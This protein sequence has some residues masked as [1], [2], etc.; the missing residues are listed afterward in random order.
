MTEAEA[1]THLAQ[2]L[3]SFTTGSILHLLADLHRDA[4][5]EARQNDDAIAFEQ[6]RLVEH[7]LVVVGMG[8]DAARP[9]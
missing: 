4:A 6:A 9:T 8:I 1:K 3:D 7:T 2:M 5:D